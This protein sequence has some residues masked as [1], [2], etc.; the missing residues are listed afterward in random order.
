M[1]RVLVDDDGCRFSHHCCRQVG[2][3]IKK[4][5]VDR[6]KL[7]T[8]LIYDLLIYFFIHDLDQH[9]GRVSPAL[10]CVEPSTPRCWRGEQLG[11]HGC[12]VCDVFVCCGCCRIAS[13]SLYLKKWYKINLGIRLTILLH[14]PHWHAPHQQSDILIAKV[15]QDELK[16]IAISR[17]AWLGPPAIAMDLRQ[18]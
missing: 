10:Y 18:D 17:Q 1:I 9:L 14:V 8:I 4:I 6:N 16:C 13:S 2:D 15:I 7:I 11:P 3:V 12:S 5:E